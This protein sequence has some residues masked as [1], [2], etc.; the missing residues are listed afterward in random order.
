MIGNN[1]PHCTVCYS[2][3][4]KVTILHIPYTS[5]SWCNNIPELTE[6]IKFINGSQF[7][8]LFRLKETTTKAISICR[9]IQKSTGFYKVNYIF[10]LLGLLMNDSTL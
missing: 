2:S 7:G 6:E 4:I 9:K 10:E 3:D 5:L 8:Y 1:L